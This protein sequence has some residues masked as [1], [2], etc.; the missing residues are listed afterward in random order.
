M[1][2]VPT[3]ELVANLFQDCDPNKA[4]YHGLCKYVGTTLFVSGIVLISASPTAIEANIFLLILTAFIKIPLTAWTF[5]M[6][7]NY[8][9]WP[10]FLV[11]QTRTGPSWYLPA[12]HW[13]WGMR[14]PSVW[15]DHVR[16]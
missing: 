1:E 3:S 10:L 8:L 4:D 16:T 15:L 6:M 14:G 2:S 13:D 9:S 7:V 11:A 12:D 5:G